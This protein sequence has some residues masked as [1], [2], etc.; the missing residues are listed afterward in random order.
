[1]RLHNFIDSVQPEGAAALS[2]FVRSAEFNSIAMKIVAE[3]F[4]KK[5]PGQVDEARYDAEKE[6]AALLKLQMPSFSNALCAE[7]SSLLVEQIVLDASSYLTDSH[8]SKFLPKQAAG[9]IARIA[10]GQASNVDQDCSVISAIKSL[11]EIEKFERD[12]REQIKS[13]HSKMRLPHWGTKKLVAWESLYVQPRIALVS[14]NERREVHREHVSLTE[15]FASSTR[16]VIL[17]DPGG[18]KSTLS[19]KT[20]YD[21]AIG[22]DHKVA[23]A[24]VPMVVVLRDFAVA[25]QSKKATI[26]EHL[27]DLCRSPYEL[28]PPDGAIEYLLLTGRAFVIFD[29]LDELIDTSLRVQVVDAV[30]AFVNRYPTTPVL[31]TSR[32]IGYE[33]APLDP[34][35]FPVVSLGQFSDQQVSTYARQWFSQDESLSAD[36]SETMAKS[37]LAESIVVQD[38][39]QNPLMLSLMCGIYSVENYIPRNRPDIYEKCATMLFERWDKQRSIVVPLPFDALIKFA[40]YAL[41]LWLYETPA[42][43]QGLTRGALIKF[44]ANYLREKRFDNDE[45]AE[46]AATSFVDFCTGRAWVMTDVG[47]NP[48]QSLFGF[49][50]RTFLEYFAACQI[51]RVRRDAVLLHDL[52]ASKIKKAEWDVVAQLALQL[53]NEAA[54]DGADDFMA[55]LLSERHVADLDERTNIESFL[56]RSLSFVVP[57][58]DLVKEIVSAAFEAY[59]LQDNSVDSHLVSGAQIT[60]VA[61][62]ASEL[63]PKVRDILLDL[64]RSRLG[65]EDEEKALFFALY[66][67]DFSRQR[68]QSRSFL[69]REGLDFWKSVGEDWRA[70]FNSYVTREASWPWLDEYAVARGIIGINE[71]LFRNDLG[72]LFIHGRFG[73]GDAC[74]IASA[75]FTSFRG[76]RFRTDLD[77]QK[78][79][80][81]G[82]FDELV[83]RLLVAPTPWVDLGQFNKHLGFSLGSFSDAESFDE[84]GARLEL[85]L[86]LLAFHVEYNIVVGL[87]SEGR[88]RVSTFRSVLVASGNDVGRKVQDILSYLQELGVHAAV[89]ELLSRWLSRQ[90][91]LVR[92]VVAVNHGT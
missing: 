31:V 74:S 69:S 80:S 59:L 44:M 54:E 47:S 26:A 52:L 9:E 17:G 27:A 55:L 39:R 35:L 24:S 76:G 62:A 5:K 2:N 16:C 43:Q 36:Q 6:L 3:Y 85:F 84:R 29:G 42:R 32:R 7:A 46:N 45:E 88:N 18:G 73:F 61:C 70:K 38:L 78:W 21:L 56:A 63:L 71:Y 23:S 20:A 83:N 1:M 28:N 90:V 89:I 77:W 34:E 64:V 60:E 53:F 40:L 65:T 12:L 4:I 72:T 19:F 58:P 91:D 8:L 11:A 81:N 22:S 10:A 33:E 14:N 50:H 66:V 82:N 48:S 41:A 87:L 92:D 13:T 67:E 57:R 49:T 68:N 51:V 30:H 86:L 75:L 25:F 79:I 15:I 37:F